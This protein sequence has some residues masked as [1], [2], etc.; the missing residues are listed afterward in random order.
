MPESN[1]AGISVNAFPSLTRR[2]KF[3][4]YRNPKT[5]MRTS[6]RRSGAD[7]DAD[8]RGLALRLMDMRVGESY[9]ARQA[10]GTARTAI[11]IPLSQGPPRSYG[12]VLFPV[13]LTRAV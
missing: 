6:R 7:Y 3:K 8:H 11:H 5:A 9:R 2:R 4:P 1:R 13:D 10:R 12:P